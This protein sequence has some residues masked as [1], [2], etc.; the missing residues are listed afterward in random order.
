[1]I[2]DNYGSPEKDDEIEDNYQDE[3]QDHYDSQTPV[4]LELE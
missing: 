1:M 4:K 3:I 2:Q